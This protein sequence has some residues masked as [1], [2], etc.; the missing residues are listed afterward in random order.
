MN[1]DLAS[2]EE[3]LGCF[4]EA[5]MP[6]EPAFFQSAHLVLLQPDIVW[7]LLL[8]PDDHIGTRSVEEQLA[9]ML[10]SILIRFQFVRQ[11]ACQPTASPVRV[12][13]VEVSHPQHLG[14]RNL[15]LPAT[16]ADAVGA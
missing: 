2:H 9:R 10:R 3:R 4:P 7:A 16:E 5:L 14:V 8:G 15:A 12:R 1:I 13:R 11:G 6:I